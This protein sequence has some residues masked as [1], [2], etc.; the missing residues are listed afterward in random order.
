MSGEDERSLSRREELLIDRALAGL[1]AS[2]AAELQASSSDEDD[3]EAFDRAAAAIDLGCFDAP[4]EPLP[5]ALRARIEASLPEVL[6]SRRAAAPPPRASDA[7][8]GRAPALPLGDVV[9]MARGR[10]VDRTRWLGWLVAAACLA[11]ALA[12]WL[13][14]SAPQ[15]QHVPA[16]PSAVAPPPAPP[17]P[18]SILAQ[19]ATLLATAKDVVRVDWSATKDASATGA[20]GDVVWSNAEQRGYMRFR[21]LAPNDPAQ[22]QFQ[23]W[24]FDRSQDARFPIDGGVFDV[25]AATGE[26]IVPITAKIRVTQPTLFAVTVEK[27]GGVVVSKREHIVL[28]AAV[29]AG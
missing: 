20:S 8:P 18:P 23:L 21:G 4:S 28:T 22:R 9:P 14:R 13:S 1:D 24:I 2:E 5:E 26:V 10:A 19:R 6:A 25:D 3:D 11:L 16:L 12:S 17:P 27:P 15:A 7:G 29:S